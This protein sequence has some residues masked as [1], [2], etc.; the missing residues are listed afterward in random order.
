MST[1]STMVTSQA[2]NKG[3]AL[4]SEI[5]M[6][7][8][9]NTSLATQVTSMQARVATYQTQLQTEFSN[10]DQ[11]VNTERSLYQEVGGSGTFM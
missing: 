2:T 8:T 10:M 4:Q 11:T 5:S 3:S 7:Q 1:L 6:Y 9:R